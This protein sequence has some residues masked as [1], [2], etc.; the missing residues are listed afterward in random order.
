MD[1]LDLVI[2]KHS[3]RTKIEYASEKKR[4]KTITYIHIY[5]K[6]YLILKV[7]PQN[8]KVSLKISLKSKYLGSLFSA[9]IRTVQV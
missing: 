9:L 8:S 1:L 3:H 4:L 2:E 6:S 7:A 5:S